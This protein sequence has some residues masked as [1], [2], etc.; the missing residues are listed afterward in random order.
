LPLFDLN[1]KQSTKE[2]FGRQEELDEI[3]R[4]IRAKRWVA[5]LG[6]RMVGKTSL[7]KVANTKIDSPTVY[8]NLWGAKTVSSL[9]N[10]L[11]S[12]LNSSK[13]LYQKIKDG[14]QRIEGL[15]I[16]TNGISVT[17]SRRPLR[18]TSSLF[19]VIGK[20]MRNSVIELD[21]IQEL[22][23][24]SGQ[25]LKMLANIFN[26][27]PNIT[28]VF[29]GSMFGLMKTLLEPN[30]SSPMYGRAP[31][32]IYLHAFEASK[33]KNFLK[34]GFDEY[35]HKTSEEQL[36]EA[37]E[38]LD[39]IPGWLTLYGNNIALQKIPQRRALQETVAEGIKVVKSELEHFLQG[40]DRITYLTALRVAAVPARWN[41]IKKAIEA[42]RDSPVNDA[43]LRN[44][45]ESLKSAMLVEERNGERGGVYHVID[46][47]LRELLLSAGVS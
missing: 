36:D 6:P 23:S 21:E 47:I 11:V 33:A 38:K 32:K 19:E 40:R 3:V 37:V 41:E 45:L 31:A 10:A 25:L 7:I 15:S 14:L 4:L 26:T 44:T 27:Y 39:G 8:L 34:R 5:V 13:S 28:F 18:T 1:P 16:G 46:P 12:A 30:S 43:T 24:V 22:S 29:T 42:K 9:L 2:L 35:R 20:Q 17:I